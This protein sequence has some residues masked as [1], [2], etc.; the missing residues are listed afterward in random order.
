MPNG[1]PGDHPITDTIKHGMKIFPDDIEALL[2]RI[3]E[4]DPK[5]LI[6]PE[7]DDSLGQGHAALKATLEQ[8]CRDNELDK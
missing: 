7:V 3:Y 1:K 8:I 2:L 6:V 4:A 5:L